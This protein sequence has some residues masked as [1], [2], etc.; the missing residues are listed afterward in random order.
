MLVLFSSNIFI[1]P[2]VVANQ[3]DWRMVTLTNI[4][5]YLAFFI[6]VLIF[7]GRKGLMFFIRYLLY[8]IYTLT[9]IPIT[10]QGILRKNN[11]EWNP[12]KHVRN[13]EIY[14]V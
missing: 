11:Q 13:V 6:A 1:M 10:I 9:W 2:L 7:L 14:D 4:G 5:F 3:T 12:T 8:S